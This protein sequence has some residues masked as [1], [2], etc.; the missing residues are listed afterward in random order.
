MSQESH[1]SACSAS[2]IDVARH[3]VHRRDVDEPGTLAVGEVQRP[4]QPGRQG[5]AGGLGAEPG[6]GSRDVEAQLAVEQPGR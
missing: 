1:S 2:A 4:A 5:L 6:L 3:D